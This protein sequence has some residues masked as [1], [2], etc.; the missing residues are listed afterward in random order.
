MSF[1]LICFRKRRGFWPF[2]TRWSKAGHE[3]F[4]VRGRSLFAVPYSVEK[5]SFQ[6]GKPQT[7]FADRLEM[8]APFSSYD[9]SPDGQHFV[10][11]QFPGAH[12][13]EV[14]EPT[15]V[16]NWLDQPRQLVPDAQTGNPK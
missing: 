9:V 8:R 2:Q 14:S 4:Y 16:L 11:F 3:L 13:V 12:T 15:V 1:G 10:I 7:L 5:N 6:A